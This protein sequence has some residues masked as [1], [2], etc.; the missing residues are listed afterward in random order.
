MHVVTELHNLVAPSC[1]VPTP[2]LF[3]TV[4]LLPFSLYLMILLLI[5]NIPCIFVIIYMHYHVSNH[6]LTELVWWFCFIVLKQ[7]VLL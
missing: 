1:V 7:A 4:Y 5:V 6:S 2:Q 3:V